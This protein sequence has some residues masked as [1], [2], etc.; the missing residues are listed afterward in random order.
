MKAGERQWVL[1]AS[2][3]SYSS[4]RTGLTLTN[5]NL[6]MTSTDGKPVRVI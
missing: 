2:D 6:T 5:A 4:T 1:T 3:A